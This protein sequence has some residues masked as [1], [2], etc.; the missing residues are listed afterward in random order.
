[1]FLVIVILIIASIANAQQCTLVTGEILASAT[2]GI[3]CEE[4]SF[5]GYPD[6]ATSCEC[7]SSNMD[8]FDACS[9]AGI[10]REDIDFNIS[11][12]FA[13]CTCFNNSDSGYW[14]LNSDDSVTTYI[15][16]S[17][18]F[19]YGNDNPPTCNECF[20]SYYGP[21]PGLMTPSAIAFNISAC[22]SVGGVDPNLEFTAAPTS[23]ESRRRLIIETVEK[24]SEYEEAREPRDGNWKVCAGHGDW[25]ERSHCECDVGWG[26]RRVVGVAADGGD[27]YICDKCAGPWGPPT[28]AQAKGIEEVSQGPYC[29]FPWTPDPIDEGILK[30]CSGH[31]LYLD[32]MCECYA[33]EEQGFW[34][35]EV[36]G[37]VEEVYEWE[38]GVYERVNTY[39]E[40]LTCINC[41]DGFN[42][43]TG[44]RTNTTDAPTFYPTKDPTVDPTMN[45]T[46]NPTLNPTINPTENPTINPTRPPTFNPTTGPTR[47][48]SRNPSMN[49][50]RHPSL[51][52]TV[53]PTQNPTLNPTK[54]P[55]I[56][57]TLN[58]TLTPTV[59]PTLIPTLNPTENPTENP[60]TNPT[61]N[62]TK[63]PTQNP[64]TNPTEN[65][66]TNPTKNPTEN[67]TVNPT[68]NPTQNPTES[69]GTCES[70]CICIG[71]T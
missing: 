38:A 22:T 3:L 32:G 5:R 44:C 46:V 18:E 53:I 62:P 58:P 11:V 9:V 67:P 60:T 41:Q 24:L 54:N 17:A 64:T 29:V 50:T 15:N 2:S 66:T 25:I 30:E 19:V 37:I 68:Q 8:P 36:Y 63:N 14:R 23:E 49:P 10:E 56:N 16:S 43:D 71:C 31:G 55:S 59:N 39:Y 12:A 28:R 65:P 52:P 47:N 21:P 61:T 51:N 40:V 13:S 42:Y 27:L 33:N 20:N 57:P 7:I 45:P 34:Q 4:C 6:T 35:L 70:T 69:C 48:P 1:M 26:L